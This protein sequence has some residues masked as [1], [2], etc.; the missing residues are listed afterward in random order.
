MITATTY[1]TI[2]I[3]DGVSPNELLGSTISGRAVPEV[4]YYQL[5]LIK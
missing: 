4:D 3:L 5:W 1:A 2:N